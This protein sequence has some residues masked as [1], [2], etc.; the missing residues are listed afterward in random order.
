M[1][2]ILRTLVALADIALILWLIYVAF[3]DGL[4][5]SM[6]VLVFISIL[7]LTF[8][9]FYFIV[10]RGEPSDWLSLFFKRKALEEQRKI[11][12]LDPRN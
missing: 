11:E 6:E 2:N 3:D 10:T 5:D 7:L 4:D 8:F 12:N 1:K 9:N